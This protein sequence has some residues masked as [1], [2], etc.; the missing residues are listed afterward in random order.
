MYLVGLHIYYKMIYGPYNIKSIGTLTI[1]C[2]RRIILIS[3]NNGLSNCYIPWRFYMRCF[4]DIQLLCAKFIWS[5][6]SRAI[7]NRS[8]K[9]GSTYCSSFQLFR[10]FKLRQTYTTISTACKVY[11]MSFP[12]YVHEKYSCVFCVATHQRKLGERN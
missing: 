9:F 2:N 7:S 8:T 1:D 4:L 11:D 3:R 10:T 6:T 12:H 5:K